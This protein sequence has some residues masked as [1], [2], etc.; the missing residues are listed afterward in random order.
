MEH[1]KWMRFVFTWF[2]LGQWGE[3]RSNT[4][5][6]TRQPTAAESYAVIDFPLLELIFTALQLWQTACALEYLHSGQDTPQIVHGDL[7]AVCFLFYILNQL[8]IRE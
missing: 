1:V 3:T 2:L 7:K 4:F 5:D 6:G 8:I